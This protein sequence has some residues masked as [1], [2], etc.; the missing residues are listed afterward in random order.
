MQVLRLPPYPLTV[1]YDVP[2]ANTAYKV[3]IKDHDRNNDIAEYEL[4]SDSESKLLIQLSDDFDRYDEFY[5]LEIREDGVHSGPVVVQDNLEIKRPYVD[6]KTLGT[7]ASEIAEYTKYE[8]QA[9]AIIDSIVGG[10]YFQ[11]EY[12]GTVGQGTDYIPLWKNAYKILEV[13]ENSSLVYDHDEENP[14]LGD[15]NYVITNDKTAITKLPANGSLLFNRSEKKPQRIPIAQSDSFGIFDTEDSG[16]VQS[17]TPGTVFPEGVDYLFLLE[18]GYKVVPYD[19]K[20]A[21]IMLIDDL[22][23][24]K[25]DY[26]KRYITSYSTDQYRIQVDKSSLEGTGNI[27]V[28]QILENYKVSIVRPGVL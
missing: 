7:T 9:R 20:E 8:R 19:I 1:I 22:K 17:I 13:Y 16:V 12:V 25:I 3:F 26:H 28:D 4:T 6:P 21:T 18:T 10:F 23:C 14:I 15:W 2:D 27:I 24:G 11:S 5:F